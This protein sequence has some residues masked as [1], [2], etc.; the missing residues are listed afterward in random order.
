MDRELLRLKLLL[1]ASNP[2]FDPDKVIDQG[3][4][5]LFLPGYDKY[6]NEV[7]PIQK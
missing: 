2:K 6:D 7:K 5:H 3:L 1:V 4:V